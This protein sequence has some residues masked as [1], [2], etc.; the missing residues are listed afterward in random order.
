MQY[1][2]TWANVNL[3]LCCHINKLVQERRNSIANELESRFS[4]TKAIDMM[5]WV[6]V[7]KGWALWSAKG[8]KTP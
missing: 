3:D 4:C 7:S 5:S 1:A 8:D 6:A 2:I